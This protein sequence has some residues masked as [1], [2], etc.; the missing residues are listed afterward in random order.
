MAVASSVFVL[1]NPLVGTKILPLFAQ[2][3]DFFF[4]EQFVHSSLQLAQVAVDGSLRGAQLGGDL[5]DGALHIKDARMVQ[6][7]HDADLFFHGQPVG[8]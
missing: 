5:A 2:V 4:R 3:G 1:W 7:L 6:G 8:R